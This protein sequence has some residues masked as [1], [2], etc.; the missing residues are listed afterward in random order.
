MS[1][2]FSDEQISSYF[3]GEVT[4]EERAEIE[5]LLET[6]DEA[7]REFDEYK[8][9]SALMNNLPIESAPRNLS[10]NVSRKLGPTVSETVTASSPSK[11]NQSRR[12]VWMI[13]G[14]L[15]AIAVVLLM[16]VNLFNFGPN[17]REQFELAKQMQPQADEPRPLVA[18]NESDAN[19]SR[20]SKSREAFIFGEESKAS[21]LLNKKTLPSEPAPI[22]AV[23]P[24][25]DASKPIVTPP[26]G[27]ANLVQQSN[28]PQSSLTGKNDSGLI[29][30]NLQELKDAD[31]GKIVTALEKT[32]AGIAVV[33]LTVVDRQTG[34]KSLQVLLSR[35]SISLDE[36]GKESG[37]LQT[38]ADKSPKDKSENVQKQSERLVAVYVKA[39]PQQ[40]ASALGDLRNTDLF[41]KLHVREPIQTAQLNHYSGRQVISGASTRG[42]TR[43]SST[44][45]RRRAGGSKSPVAAKES[46]DA[47]QKPELKTEKLSDQQNATY[48]KKISPLKELDR[49]SRQLE[50]SLSPEVLTE[51]AQTAGPTGRNSIGSRSPE[52]IAVRLNGKPSQPANQNK[53]NATKLQQPN[54][55][56]VLF[57]LVVNESAKPN[58]SPTVKPA[59]PTK[60]V[61]A[62][63]KSS[64]SGAA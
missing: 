50:L 7:R 3:D 54:P 18:E 29:F 2:H 26:N 21:S 53:K 11:V 19:R 20:S 12:S 31:V 25:V 58:A 60:K 4:P 44:S 42:A 30:E 28:V 57:I 10:A 48:Q 37:S 52:G 24:P 38:F 59:K 9:L 17:Q 1:K 5:R 47:F 33:K 16:T 13:A 36:K 22:A 62:L 61:R 6:S 27:T 32:N 34:L 23:K 41:Q 56:K 45:S 35:H 51:I 15:T 14:S 43:S 8:K 39:T 63:K 40:F 64:G 55:L 46:T 49:L